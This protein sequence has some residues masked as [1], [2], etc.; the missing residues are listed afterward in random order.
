MILSSSCAC[1]QNQ[2]RV[3]VVVSV[4]FTRHIEPSFEVILPLL[5]HASS[6]IRK[7]AVHGVSQLCIAVAKVAAETGDNQAQAGQSTATATDDALETV[8][9]FIADFVLQP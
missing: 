1:S 6:D 9:R 4:H 2:V 8:T 5:E 3:V 7:G